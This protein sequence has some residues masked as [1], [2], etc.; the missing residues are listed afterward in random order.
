MSFY[1]R[2]RVGE[3]LAGRSGVCPPGQDSSEGGRE[4]SLQDGSARPTAVLPGRRQA[5]GRRERQGAGARM[6]VPDGGGRRGWGRE[7]RGTLWLQIRGR[8]GESGREAGRRLPATTPISS[9]RRSVHPA[10]GAPAVRRTRVTAPR[11]L[12]AQVRAPIPGAFP[13]LATAV[14]SPARVRAAAAPRVP[15]IQ[16]RAAPRAARERAE[17]VGVNR[18][19]R[20]RGEAK[21]GGRAGA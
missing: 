1:S 2:A 11:P 9:R 16:L 18:A 3:P 6:G 20:A 14:G 21:S 13:L 15:G 10:G 17:R 8:G 19:P 4:L 5:C 7:D 12:A